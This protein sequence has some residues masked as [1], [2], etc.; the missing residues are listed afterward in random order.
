MRKKTT[1]TVAIITA[2]ID[3]FSRHFF[4]GLWGGGERGGEGTVTKYRFDTLSILRIKNAQHLISTDS[5][6]PS[7]H[8]VFHD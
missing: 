4:L 5:T 8:H 2:R 3:T 7:L 6:T 1:A